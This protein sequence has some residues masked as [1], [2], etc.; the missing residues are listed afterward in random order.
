MRHE[1]WA[2]KLQEITSLSL[3]TCDRS[4]W[5]GYCQL[6]QSRASRMWNWAV[7]RYVREVDLGTLRRGFYSQ[8]ERWPACRART[9]VP[10]YEAKPRRLHILWDLTARSIIVWLLFIG[11]WNLYPHA[12]MPASINHPSSTSHFGVGAF[13]LPYSTHTKCHI[14]FILGEQELSSYNASSSC[15]K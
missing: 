4:C 13:K 9:A 15:R 6:I 3:F 7:Q 1:T 10:S 2:Y 5:A 12:V 14:N 11:C 8:I